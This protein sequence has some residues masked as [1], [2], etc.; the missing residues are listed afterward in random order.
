MEFLA[1]DITQITGIKRTRL[2]QWLERGFVVPSIQVASGP[3]TRNIYSRVDL[4]NIAT[5]KKIT[6]SGLPR[7]VVAEFISLGAVGSKM[8][9]LELSEITL[10]FYVRYGDRTEAHAINGHVINLEHAFAEI[11]PE[12]TKFY[13]IEDYDDI[14]VINFKKIKRMVDQKIKEIKG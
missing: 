5:F 3:G 7:K 2:Q 4:Y 1:A 13:P 10:I 8:F 14:Y 12:G 6:E 11:T 9:D